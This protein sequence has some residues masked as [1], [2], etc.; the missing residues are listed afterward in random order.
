[1]SEGKN[2]NMIAVVTTTIFVPKAL[3]AYMENVKE[4]QQD[5]HVF[6]VVSNMIRYIRTAKFLCF[7]ETPCR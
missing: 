4:F 2:P 7:P 6:F 1:M 3:R 5:S